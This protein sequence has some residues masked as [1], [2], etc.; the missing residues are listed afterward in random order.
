MKL[1]SRTTWFESLN[2]KIRLLSEDN[3]QRPQQYSPRIAIVGIGNELRGDDSAGLAVARALRPLVAGQD[4]ILVID[5]GAAPEN[6]TGLLR[7]FKPD[8]ILLVDAAQLNEV[9]GTIHWLDWQETVGM[10]A[11]THTL[12]LHVLSSYLTAELG[13]QVAIIGIQA[14][15]STIG[16]PLSTPVAQAV[17]RIV[18]ALSSL[19]PE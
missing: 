17:E 18:Q 10:S 15:D 3:T 5:A 4:N 14:Q 13:C 12:P 9:P 11:S 7:R 1:N 6:F 16:K 19:K 2:R 8:L